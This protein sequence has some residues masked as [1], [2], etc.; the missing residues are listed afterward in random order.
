MKTVINRIFAASLC[1]LFVL[2]GTAL[3]AMDTGNETVTG[4]DS[5]ERVLTAEE[6][7]VYELLEDIVDSEAISAETALLP[8]YEVKVYNADSELVYEGTIDMTEGCADA[9]GRRIL[10]KSDLMFQSGNVKY[11]MT[12]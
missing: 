10:L 8:G 5:E 3:Q 6:T 2:S 1:L 7:E 11:F 9:K 12:R 4:S